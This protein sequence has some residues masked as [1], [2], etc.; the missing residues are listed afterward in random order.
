MSAATAATG[1]PVN[2]STA[3]DAFDIPAIMT[4]HES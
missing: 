1:Q 2:R 3:T 4:D